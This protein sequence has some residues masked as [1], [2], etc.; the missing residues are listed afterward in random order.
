MLG[1]PSHSLTH[2]D[3]RRCSASHTSG[4]AV[5]RQGRGAFESEQTQGAGRRMVDD[6]P[7]H[8]TAERNRAESLA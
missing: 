5:P 3:K 4:L 6:G 7:A 2:A 8:P 1:D